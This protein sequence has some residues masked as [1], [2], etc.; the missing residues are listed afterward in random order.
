MH[1]CPGTG[2]SAGA[3]RSLFRV[4]GGNGSWYLT[5]SGDPVPAGKA[6]R[7]T[8]C[9]RR[10][11][12]GSDKSLVVVSTDKRGVAWVQS[13]GRAGAQEPI[14]CASRAHLFRRCIGGFPEV[15]GPF[16]P[17]GWGPENM[18]VPMRP[19]LALSGFYVKKWKFHFCKCL[20]LEKWCRGGR[21]GTK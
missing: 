7:A 11:M 6:P 5:V 17:A 15:F 10:R 13:A 8:G 9:L 1:R 18:F 14:C 20:N 12:N 16:D 3:L 2:F 4:S 21:V 19:P